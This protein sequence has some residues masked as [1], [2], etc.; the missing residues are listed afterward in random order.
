MSSAMD[1]ESKWEVLN[2]PRSSPVPAAPHNTPTEHFMPPPS[3]A[4]DYKLDVGNSIYECRPTSNIDYIFSDNKEHPVAIFR[5]GLLEWIDQSAH[6]EHMLNE[7]DFL[8]KE[9][10]FL[11]RKNEYCVDTLDVMDK[12]VIQYELLYLKEKVKNYENQFNSSDED[13]EYSDSEYSSC[14]D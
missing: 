1:I 5:D 2:V 11:K 14:E 13:E 7:Y 10:D 8:K 9:N 4:Q 12:K 6:L 3:G